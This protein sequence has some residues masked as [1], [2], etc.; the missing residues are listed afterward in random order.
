MDKVTKAKNP[1]LFSSYGVYPNIS[2][3]LPRRQ[4]ALIPKVSPR[5]GY[6]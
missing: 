5:R 2:L 4:T 6:I 1:N 3:Q